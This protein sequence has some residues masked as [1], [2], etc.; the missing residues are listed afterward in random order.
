MPEILP[1][2]TA[3]KSAFEPSD[4]CPACSS[5]DIELLRIAHRGHIVS[6][7]WVILSNAELRPCC[8]RG[9]G[10]VYESRGVRS[11]LREFYE[12]VFAPT[13]LMKF[14]GD[15]RTQLVDLIGELAAIPPMGRLLEVGAGRGQFLKRFH[16][17]YPEWH[18]TAIE[19]SVSFDVLVKTVPTAQAHRCSFEAYACAPESQDIVVALSV[20][21]TVDDPLTLL[22]WFARA[23]KKG[24][25]CFLEASNFETHP[26]SL[27]CGDHLSKLTPLTMENLAARAGFTVEATRPAGVPMYCVLRAIGPTSEVPPS[28]FSH[29]IRVVRRNER[30]VG[31]ILKSI[32]D[33]HANARRHDE[34]FAIFGL[35]STG[36]AA[37]FMLGFP[38]SDIAAFIDDN[39]SAWGTEVIGRPVI[40]PDL[41]HRNGIKHIALSLS[42][43]YAEQVCAKLRPLGVAIY[44]ASDRWPA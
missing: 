9:C 27:V 22:K 33:A 42:P 37:P 30:L 21:Q 39:T 1:G 44:A 12:E 6:S 16:D 34:R 26:N 11:S 13:P 10:L 29:N 19:P 43:V 24:G 8:C 38:P 14:Y 28:A 40:G 36:L 3:G 32:A 4:R 17:V 15:G 25:I 7:N 18:L 5:E 41:I 20:I 23:L 35:A 2:H 31:Q